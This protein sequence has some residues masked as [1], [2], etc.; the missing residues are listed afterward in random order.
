MRTRFQSVEDLF[1][2]MGTMLGI[3]AEQVAKMFGPRQPPEPTFK[4]LEGEPKEIERVCHCCERPFFVSQRFA[5]EVPSDSPWSFCDRCFDY[6]STGDLTLSEQERFPIGPPPRDI[7]K[8][9]RK[10]NSSSGRDRQR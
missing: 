6:A 8:Q 2:E 1:Q 5:D 7:E 4:E 3:E 10:Q 9:I